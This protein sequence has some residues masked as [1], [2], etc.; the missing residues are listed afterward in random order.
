MIMRNAHRLPH[1]G[2]LRGQAAALVAHN[3]G[4]GRF[5]LRHSLIQR[6]RSVQ[7][8]GIQHMLRK[9]RAV[10]GKIIIIAHVQA[11]NCAHAGSHHMRIKGVRRRSDNGDIPISKAQRR[12]QHGA[13]VPLVAGMVQRQMAPFSIERALKLIK[14]HGGKA[15]LLA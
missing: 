7:H 2:K 11:E 6:H 14:H 9:I 15:I 12:A 13:Q 4:E 5:F 10:G 1:G 8:E 3:Q